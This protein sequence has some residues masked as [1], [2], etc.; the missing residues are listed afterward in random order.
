ML[1]RTEEASNF[2]ETQN[3]EFTGKHSEKRIPSKEE[4]WTE[5]GLITDK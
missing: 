3:V 2:T 1:E 4:A 5:D